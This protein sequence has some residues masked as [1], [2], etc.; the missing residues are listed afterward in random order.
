MISKCPLLGIV[1]DTGIGPPVQ[2]I[3]AADKV[4]SEHRGRTQ[5]EL[6]CMLSR[7][8]APIF[9]GGGC[10]GGLLYT[11]S[12]HCAIRDYCKACFCSDYCGRMLS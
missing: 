3:I 5:T 1:P 11:V 6:C 12:E 8:A 4:S 10:G 2:P 9:R 7:P